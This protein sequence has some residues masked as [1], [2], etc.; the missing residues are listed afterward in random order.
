MVSH[1]GGHHLGT[2]KEVPPA[3]WRAQRERGRGK[4]V[5]ACKCYDSVTVLHPLWWDF[6]KRAPGEA[7]TSEKEG[8]NQRHQVHVGKV[9]KAV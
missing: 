4:Q 2:D 1:I 7:G 5:L 3:S 8:G 9:Q 6:V